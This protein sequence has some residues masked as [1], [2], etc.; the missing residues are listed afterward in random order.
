MTKTILDLDK[1]VEES[2]KLREKTNDEFWRRAGEQYAKYLQDKL[3][4]LFYDFARAPLD[5]LLELIAEGTNRIPFPSPIGL[6]QADV[7]DVGTCLLSIPRGLPSA[8]DGA[9]F[10]D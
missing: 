6:P 2:R 10:S 1:A 9:C 5:L 7:Y 4:P 8:I 3:T